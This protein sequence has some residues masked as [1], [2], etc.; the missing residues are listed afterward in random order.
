MNSYRGDIEACMNKKC[1]VKWQCLRWQIAL[2][3]DPNQTY[4]LGRGTNGCEFQ[5]NVN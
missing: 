3:N 1:R 2:S 5:I 4:I